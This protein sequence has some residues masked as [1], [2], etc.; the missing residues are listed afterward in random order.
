VVQCSWLEVSKKR[1]HLTCYW[2][3]HK[4]TDG[5]TWNVKEKRITERRGE[6]GNQPL[7]ILPEMSLMRSGADDEVDINQKYSTCAGSHGLC[8]SSL[9]TW[10]VSIL[11]SVCKTM[12]TLRMPRSYFNVNLSLSTLGL[13]PLKTWNMSS[14]ADGGGD[15]RANHLHNHLFFFKINLPSTSHHMSEA[16]LKGD[17][18]SCV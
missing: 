9:W 6:E 15:Q 5:V 14:G 7:L 12:Q 10:P 13:N 17:L 18:V 3:H 2:V 11:E 16:N 4:Q 1:G 8:M